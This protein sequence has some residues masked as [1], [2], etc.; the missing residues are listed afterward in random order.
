[1]FLAGVTI[2]EAASLRPVNRGKL[3]AGQLLGLETKYSREFV[4]T[5]GEML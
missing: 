4:K 2:L 5:L 3:E 1:V